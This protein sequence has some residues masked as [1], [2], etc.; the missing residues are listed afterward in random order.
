MRAHWIAVTVLLAGLPA[1]AQ[2]PASPAP[3]SAPAGPQ[4]S[5]YNVELIVFR[6]ATALGGKEEW[7]TEAGGEATAGID[8]DSDPG[9]LGAGLGAPAAVVAP[10]A[11]AS[12]GQPDHFLRLLSPAEFQLN[13]I[14]AKLRA[15]GTYVPVAHFA[16]SQTA[17]PWGNHSGIALQRLGADAAGLSGTASLERGQFLHLAL[18]LNY[19]MSDPP[20]GL[21]AGPGTV[22]TLNDI[23]RVRFYERNY[24]DHPAFGVIA[25]VTPAQGARRAGR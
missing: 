17:S 23:H 8:S 11:P 13:D 14:E 5:A 24:F 18:A 21:G 19:E 9:A 20:A 25:L 16:W 2:Q 10:V 22:F 6:A 7:S 4:A 15:S 12:P 3:A 1:A